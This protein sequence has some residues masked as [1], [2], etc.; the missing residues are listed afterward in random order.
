MPNLPCY[1]G[2]FRMGHLVEA[3]LNFHTIQ[4]GLGNTFVLHLK[5]L[6]LAGR[7]GYDLLED[8]VARLRN[9]RDPITN[10]T[11]VRKWRADLDNVAGKKRKVNENVQVPVVAEEPLPFAKVGLSFGELAEPVMEDQHPHTT[12]MSNLPGPSSHQELPAKFEELE[13]NDND[14]GYQSPLEDDMGA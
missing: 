3:T 6:L 13:D 14:M 9:V 7:L 8:E 11:I 4:I 10:P 12:V 2:S 1:P 5:K